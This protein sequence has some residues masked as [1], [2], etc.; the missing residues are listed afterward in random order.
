MLPLVTG[1]ILNGDFKLLD[2]NKVKWSFVNSRSVVL[3]MLFN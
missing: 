3:A 1:S 2:L